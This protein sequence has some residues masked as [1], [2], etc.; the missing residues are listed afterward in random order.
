MIT[1]TILAVAFVI[2]AAIVLALGAGFVVVFGDVIV[3]VLV[4]MAI[5]KFIGWLKNRNK[6]KEEA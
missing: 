5:F 2:V 3:A 1:L 6:E 4:I